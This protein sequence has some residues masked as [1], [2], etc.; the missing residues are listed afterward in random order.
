MKLKSILVLFILCSFIT[1]NAQNKTKK[2]KIV[3]VLSF[4]ILHGAT[5]KGD[6][7]LDLLAEVIKSADPDFVAMQE[8]DFKTKRAKNYDLTTE[9]GYRT[10][11]APIFAKA[12]SF[13][14]GEY[15][16][17]ILSKYTFLTTKNV[18]LPYSKGSEPRAAIEITTQ[19]ISGDTISFVATHLDHLKN[20]KDRIA[21][22]K[23]INTEFSSNQ[24][25]TILVGDMN[26][27]PGSKAINILEKIWTGSYDK[28]N[29]EPTYPSTN[30]KKKIDYVFFYPKNRWKVLKTEVI[31]NTIASDHCAYLVTLELLDE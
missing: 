10:K 2:A 29:P 25:P 8:V 5:T 22:V 30:P 21:Q 27:V 28:K 19:I 14:G 1:T 9:L 12:M 31:K 20:G 6:F 4:N 3:K 17:G 13:D 26:A 15:G 23:K 11:M 18:A 7:N 16:E 24:Y